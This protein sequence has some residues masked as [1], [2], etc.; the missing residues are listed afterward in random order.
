MG[1]PQGPSGFPYITFIPFATPAVYTQG[2][3][4]TAWAGCTASPSKRQYLAKSTISL[5]SPTQGWLLKVLTFY[6]L[7]SKTWER[8]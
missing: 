3:Q 8:H 6:L 4:T 1:N 7:L 5:P 2:L